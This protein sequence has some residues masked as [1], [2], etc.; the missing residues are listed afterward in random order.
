MNSLCSSWARVDTLHA[1]KIDIFRT[2]LSALGHGSPMKVEISES[3]Q[4]GQTLPHKWFK[5]CDVHEV[6]VK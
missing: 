1:H 6:R 4:L 2:T 5:K 3:S